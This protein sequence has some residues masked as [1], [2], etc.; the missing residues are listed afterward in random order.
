[1]LLEPA[2]VAAKG[3]SQVFEIQRRMRVWHPR[4]AA[5][6]GAGTVGLLATLMLR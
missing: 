5:V 4:R 3:I 1:M 2:S 6:L